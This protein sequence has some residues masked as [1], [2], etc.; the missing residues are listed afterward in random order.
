MS[1]NVFKMM[2]ERLTGIKAGNALPAI[3]SYHFN[4]KEAAILL[5]LPCA[6]EEISIRTGHSSKY[7]LDTIEKAYAKGVVCRDGENAEDDRY[8]LVNDVSETLFDKRHFAEFGEPYIE[9]W[10]RLWSEKIN[11]IINSID[12]PLRLGRVLPYESRVSR[13]SVISDEESVSSIVRNSRVRA[14]V[15]CICRVLNKRCGNSNESCLMFDDAAEYFIERGIGVKLSVEEAMSIIE[16]SEKEG[17]IHSTSNALFAN[18]TGVE[19]ICNCCKCC[20]IFFKLYE[21]SSWSIRPQGSSYKAVLEESRCSKCRQCTRLC[22]FG[23]IKYG[24]SAVAI[25]AQTCVGCGICA[26]H[27]SNNAIELQKMGGELKLRKTNAHFIGP[28]LNRA[29]YG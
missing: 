23:A 22:P 3:L 29:I 13:Q 5:E 25:N 14:K 9:L 19:C 20:C 28:K 12:G 11:R 21:K 4:E 2:A 6:I 8:H 15:D 24:G 18:E 17:L 10:K 16:K 1:R 26:E 7:V 27:C